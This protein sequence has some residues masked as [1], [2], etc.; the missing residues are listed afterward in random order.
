[1]E[2]PKCGSINTASTGL[3]AKKKIT[4][5]TCGHEIDTKAGRLVSKVC[6]K[7][8]K[9]FVYDQSKP[10]NRRCPA[11]GESIDAARM[12]TANYKYVTINCPQCACG[13]EVDK[14]IEIDE[15]PICGM[16]IDVQSEIK[17]QML[18]SDVGISVIQYEGDNNTFIW[19]H[20]IEDFNYGS[21]L[22]VHE[23]QEAIFFLNGQALDLFGPGRHE[24]KTESI[25]GLKKLYEGKAGTQSPFHAEV[26]FINK[27]IQ[28]LTWGT[29]PKI[30]YDDPEMETSISLGMFGEY[31]LFVQ[32]ARKLLVKVL[33]TGMQLTRESWDEDSGAKSLREESVMDFF[34]LAVRSR[35]STAISQ[36]M[37][38][39]A[40]S[41][42]SVESKKDALGEYMKGALSDLFLDYG[43][44][45][46]QFSVVGIAYPED[47]PNYQRW[48]NLRGSG[49]FSAKMKSE[50][51]KGLRG[52][53]ELE[54][55]KAEL[56]ERKRKRLEA[57]LRSADI[58]AETDMAE[59][60]AR[61]RAERLQGLTEAEIMQ[62]KG[63]NQKDVLAA[64]VQ[65]AYAAGM[66]QMG[67]N[68]GSAGGGS[69]IASDM[70]GMM[71][72]AKIA[73]TMMDQFDKA[74]GGSFAFGADA[75]PA[76]V[77]TWDC[78]CGQKGIT[79]KFCSNCGK[80]K[81]E[82][83][84]CVCGQKG[85]TGKFCSNCGQPKP[86]TWDC[87]CGQKGNTGK[88]CSNCG[89]QKAET[90][91]CACGQKGN[92]GKFCLNCGSP[93]AGAAPKSDTWNCACGQQNNT[94]K[95]C[96]ECGAARPE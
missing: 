50:E 47:D 9:V 14:N 81:P 93:K 35:I 89:Q 25:P 22:I 18:V 64:D 6:P 80:S 74:Q 3:F 63:Y 1:M 43:L 56:E 55:V 83:W 95:C 87:A 59:E 39:N 28:G 7:C 44:A 38:Q 12:A 88:F 5:G 73:N 86:E 77:E 8:E 61:I 29:D 85:I 11:C 70:V 36:F 49:T 79:G 78:A 19:K 31:K 68:G 72:G 54:D 58:K 62:A 17:K 75:A 57:E 32:D 40:V 4:C 71:M 33:G 92:T 90:W 48:K 45:I 20:P 42:F 51:A 34:D 84:D 41:V 65:K 23:S 69:G 15:C 10:Q 46:G 66:G 67:S 24:L 2:C 91:D 96:P 52:E 27:T 21:L 13:I 26:Y 16:Q 76:G 60:R 82:T 94:G 37:T 30:Q 53:F